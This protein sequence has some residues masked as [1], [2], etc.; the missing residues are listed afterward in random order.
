MQAIALIIATLIPLLVLVVIRALD[1]YQTGEFRNV[2]LCFAWGGI[3]FGLAYTFNRYLYFNNLATY[4]QIVRFAA[5]VG[6]EIFKALFL[7]Y[8]VR[9][10]K[11]TYFVDGAIYGFAAGMGFAVFENYQYVLQNPTAGLGTAIG[12][13][14]SVN[15]VHA[16]ATALVGISLGKSRFSRALG[17]LG[18]LIGGL[19]LG[20]MLHGLFNNIVDHDFP[21]PVLLY[22][23]VIGLSATG[24]I[25][26]II[27]RGLAE[28]RTWIEEKLG[29][30]DRVTGQE[31]K[32]VYKLADMGEI[33]K[34][35]RQ[36]FGDEKADQVEEFLLNQARLGIKRKTLDKLPDPKLRAAVEKEMAEIR[37]NMDDS[38]R[39]VGSYVMLY[40][41]NIFPEQTSPVWGLLESRIQER[42]LA[43]K[44]EGGPSL[45]AA[46][47]LQQRMAAA[48]AAK[49]AASGSETGP[50]QN[51]S[52]PA[53]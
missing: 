5:P 32:V 11:F 50:D 22:S 38:R 43:R 24:L 39:K 30:A 33:L 25:A 47:L 7:I 46:A 18:Y 48:K 34:P 6:E 17:K 53:I 16:S 1:L 37:Q 10:P 2:V 51:P 49:A 23:A 40:V 41:R 20:M 42:I 8:L 27:F 12:R 36:Q 31:A 29:M 35:L 3:A 26:S 21:G 28:Q 4:S 14:I 45:D 19:L 52:K 13:V 15:L 9:R 44:A